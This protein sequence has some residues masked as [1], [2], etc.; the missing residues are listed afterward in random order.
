MY[1]IPIIL[2]ERKGKYF[3]TM[4]YTDA[5]YLELDPFVKDNDNL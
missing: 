5:N 1:E 4:Y 3:Q 2:K